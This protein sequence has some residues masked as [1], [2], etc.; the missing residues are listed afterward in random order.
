MKIYVNFD[1]NTICTKILADQLNGFDIQFRMTRM[2]EVEILDK[3]SPEIEQKLGESLAEVGISIVDNNQFKLVHRIKETIN[4]MIYTD[5]EAH[6][7][8]TSTYLSEKLNYS[9]NYLSVVFSQTTLGSIENFVIL[10]KIDFAKTL[11]IEGKLTFAEVALKLN[12]SSSA[13]LSTQF[14]RTTG[15]TPTD[16]QNLI[17]KR[18]EH[19]LNN[20]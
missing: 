17:R 11:I 10:K 5:E 9:Y 13:H 8:K 14:K 12:Y 15:L 3:L 4:E 16:F 6:R 7:Y 20:V 2:G 19:R 18:K 1:I